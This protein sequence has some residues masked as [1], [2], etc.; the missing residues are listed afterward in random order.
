MEGGDEWGW[1]DVDYES[2]RP[3]SYGR[4]ACGL[5]GYI[6]VVGMAILVRED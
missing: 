3:C 5:T 2:K 4:A 6:K 1:S